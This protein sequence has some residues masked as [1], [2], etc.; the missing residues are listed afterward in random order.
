MKLITNIRRCDRCGFELG[1]SRHKI[2]KIDRE[3]WD[4]WS[5][6][7]LHRK[8]KESGLVQDTAF[9]LCNACTNNHIKYVVTSNG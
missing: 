7:V 5:T 3:T 1:S 6:I 2:T 4:G 9:D 8:D